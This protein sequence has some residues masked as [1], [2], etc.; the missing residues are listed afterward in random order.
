V[1][2][3]TTDIDSGLVDL[4]RCGLREAMTLSGPSITQAEEELLEELIR[5]AT[6]QSAGGPINNPF[7]SS[8]CDAPEE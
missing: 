8:R 7:S 4:S 2:T 3:S 1:K 5:E 6:G